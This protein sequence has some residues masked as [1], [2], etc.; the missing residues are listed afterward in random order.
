MSYVQRECA[1]QCLQKTSN[2]PYHIIAPRMTKY[3]STRDDRSG[4]VLS[5]TLYLFSSTFDQ[6]DGRIITTDG[7]GIVASLDSEFSLGFRPATVKEWSTFGLL[8]VRVPESVHLQTKQI[9]PMLYMP[10]KMVPCPAL[11][12]MALEEITIHHLLVEWESGILR[13]AA[14]G[15]G[16]TTEPHTSESRD[17]PQRCND[18]RCSEK[19]I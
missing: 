13:T 19:T 3:C 15:G 9:P 12:V 1:W 16:G 6:R 4:A 17:H 8:C 5:C 7:F 18:G 14:G 11:P 2:P 10:Q